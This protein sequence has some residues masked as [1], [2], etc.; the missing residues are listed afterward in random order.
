MRERAESVLLEEPVRAVIVDAAL[1]EKPVD[2]AFGDAGLDRAKHLLADAVRAQRRLDR[3]VLQHGEPAPRRL[4][5]GDDRDRDDRSPVVPPDQQVAL[6][7]QLGKVLRVQRAQVIRPAMP[8][9]AQPGLDLAMAYVAGVRSDDATGKRGGFAGGVLRL[10]PFERN[11]RLLFN[12]FHLVS[13]F[14]SVSQSA[15]TGQS[16]MISATAA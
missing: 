8:V 2:A 7:A 3:H 10:V 11:F 5:P 14:M 1:Q 9:G 15:I 6:V 12:V 4:F 13:F 16:S